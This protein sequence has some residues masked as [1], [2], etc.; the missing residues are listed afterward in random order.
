MY[1]I[2]VDLFQPHTLLVLLS[3]AALFWLWRK[4][5]DPGR[6]LWPLLLPL[7]ALAA[8]SMPVTANLMLLSL[9]HGYTPLEE[10]PPDAPAIV[11]FTAGL[12]PPGGPRGRPDLDEDSLQRGL[13]AAR[14][15]KAGPPCLVLVSGGTVEPEKPAPPCAGVLADFLVQHGVKEA[16]L[17]AETASQTTYEN[18]AA[19][20]KILRDKQ[21]SR[22]VLVAD[23]MDMPRAAACLRKQGIEV[24]PAPCHFRVGDF[25]VSGFSFVPGPVAAERV[26]RAWHEWVGLAWYRCCGRI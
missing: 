4:R 26:Q 18:A 6:R 3:C 14:L 15:Y 20:A 7:F 19:C 22:A 23:A 9:E 1:R 21:V 2:L 12:Y 16:D 5:A 25:R 17:V 24:V 10:R 13:E 8:A 11:V